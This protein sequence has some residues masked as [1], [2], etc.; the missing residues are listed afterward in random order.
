[1]RWAEGRWRKAG[2]GGDH[3]RGLGSFTPAGLRV[4]PRRGNDLSPRRRASWPAGLRGAGFNRRSPAL[5]CQPPT[6]STTMEDHH[7]RAGDQDHRRRQLP[8]P[9]LAGGDALHPRA[10]RRP[11]RRPQ[12]PG[13]GRARRD[14]RRRTLALRPQPP[15]DQ[16]HDR[17]LH[18]PARRRLHRARPRG[19]GRLPR[20]A[21]HGLPRPPRRRR[22]RPPRRGGARPPRRLGGGQAPD[23]PAAQ[24]HPDRAL[25]ARQDPPR[26]ALRRPARPGDGPRRGSAPADRRD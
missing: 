13:T 20:P 2:D 26:P 10:P 22:P 17:V 19:S 5:R 21:R 11:P 6:L 7:D 23:R 4:S 9:R 8:D 14:R 25:H 24:V 18:P 16:R 1:M 3:L 15:R 12:D